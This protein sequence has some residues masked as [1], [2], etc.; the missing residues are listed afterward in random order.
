MI[1][2]SVLLPVTSLILTRLSSNVYPSYSYIGCIFVHIP[3]TF[4]ISRFCREAT[5]THLNPQTKVLYLLLTSF[6][7]GLSSET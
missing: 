5:V 1:S 3:D 6:H 7:W 4:S 2:A